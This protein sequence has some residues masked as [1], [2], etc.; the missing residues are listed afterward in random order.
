MELFDMRVPN[1]QKASA[2]QYLQLHG[3]PVV[4]QMSIPFAHCVI[5]QVQCSRA[6]IDNVAAQHLPWLAHWSR[7]VVFKPRVGKNV[8]I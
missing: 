5:L 2:L 6:A 3:L 1:D 7:A 8:E 4:R